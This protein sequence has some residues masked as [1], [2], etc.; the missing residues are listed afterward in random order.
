MRQESQRE[1][2]RETGRS[3]RGQA[4][5]GHASWPALAGWVLFDWAAQPF[6]TLITT[7]L[8]APYFVAG[9][10]GDAVRGQ[11]IWGWTVAAAGLL[12]ALLSPPLGAIADRSGRR[13]PWIALCSL[14]AVAGMGALWFASPGEAAGG[15]LALILLAIVVATVAVE[16]AT[17]LTNAMM[18]DLVPPRQLGRLSG[19]GW[20]VGYA[21]GLIAL[22]A[23]VGLVIADPA[24]GKTLLGTSPVIALDGP[25]READRLVGPVSALWYAV[26]VLPLFLFT[27][28]HPP[29]RAS[30]EG[31]GASTGL[32]AA[33]LH[34]LMQTLRTLPGHPDAALF[35]LARMFYVDG[36]GAVFVFGGIYGASLFGW[37]ATELGLFGILL[38][39]TAGV[40]AVIG[41]VLDD[42]LGAKPVILTTLLLILAGAF[43]ILAI[44]PDRLFGV[45]EITPPAPGR[46]PLSS[47]AELAY[48]ACASVIGLMAGPLQSASRSFLA[49]LA[50]EDRMTQYFGLFAFSGKV[51]SF[52]APL[53][54]GTVTA[55]AGDQRMGVAVIALFL[56]AGFAL[57]TR[58]RPPRLATD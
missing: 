22:V 57:M 52:A 41:G 53:L 9:F 38:A 51:T 32:L 56:L 34:D 19:T 11:A 14:F 26:F 7:F 55:A 27:P 31:A 44:A 12:T 40:G 2:A 3:H 17:V 24:S 4:R 30:G 39:V 37:Q 47:P 58:V 45:M 15:R 16:F 42:R 46:A 48:L 6:Y 43:G 8:F 23:M 35:L 20:A 18:P 5:K 1:S 29:T 25:S 33:S 54:V 36:L 13:K 49:R 10:V 50:P 28:D 21:G